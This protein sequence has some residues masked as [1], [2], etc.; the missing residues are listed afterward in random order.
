M[1]GLDKRVAEAIR[2]FWRTRLAQGRKS[3]KQGLGG[4]TAVTGGAQLDGFCKLVV[5]LLTEN[6]VPDAVIFRRRDRLPSGKRRAAGSKPTLPGFFR[7]TKD[8][9]ILVVADGVLLATIEF[10]SQVGSFGNN[11]NNR[12]E[13]ALGNATDLWIAYR[14]G[15]F[16]KASRPWLGY[17]M[18]LEEAP[19]S[20]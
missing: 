7:P 11:V 4:R 12:A 5:D 2:F 19:E 13:E 6:G 1:K 14:E 10:K 20:T 8:W 15:T 17:F 18:L 16:G 9:D 3:R